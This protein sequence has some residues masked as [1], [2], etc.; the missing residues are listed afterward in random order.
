ME[1]LNVDEG[2]RKVASDGF[3]IVYDPR[4]ILQRLIDK[5]IIEGDRVYH[6]RCSIAV[7]NYG[8]S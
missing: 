2:T 1:H 4:L 7:V 8:A 6:L 5:V 3:K